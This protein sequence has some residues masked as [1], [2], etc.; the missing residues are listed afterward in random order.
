MVKKSK[1]LAALDAYKGRNYKLEKQKNLRK[2]AAKKKGLSIQVRN[3]D[4][5]SGPTG[6]ESVDGL[7]LAPEENSGGWES[8]ESEDAVAGAV[9]RRSTLGLTFSCSSV[10][11]D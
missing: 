7:K 3:S 5:K 4:A 11:S 2:Q 9:G 10:R 8:D 6:G 1:L